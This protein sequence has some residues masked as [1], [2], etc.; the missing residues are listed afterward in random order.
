MLALDGMEAPG[1]PGRS[2]DV[3]KRFAQVPSTSVHDVLAFQVGWIRIDDGDPLLSC[4]WVR[5]LTDDAAGYGEL[6]RAIQL[7]YGY[8]ERLLL[9]PDE[10]DLWSDEFN[11]LRE[12]FEAVEDQPQFKFL[13]ATPASFTG[14]YVREQDDMDP[15]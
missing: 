6:T 10:L 15:E 8:S 13:M 1:E 5:Q 2:W 11:S 9:V 12:F 7:E 3:F 4:S 14:V